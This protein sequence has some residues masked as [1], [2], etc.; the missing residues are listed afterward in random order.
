M[1]RLVT[2]NVLSLK[3]LFS[4]LKWL[5]SRL[6]AMFSRHKTIVDKPLIIR[7]SPA[8]TLSRRANCLSMSAML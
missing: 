8:F 1:S 4:R 3:R 2:L 7:Y 6:K 5:F